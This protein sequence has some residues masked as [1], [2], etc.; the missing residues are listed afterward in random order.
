MCNSSPQSSTTPTER[1][2]FMYSKYTNIQSQKNKKKE[3][4]VRERERER[5]P[6][7]GSGGVFEMKG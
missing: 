3:N 7:M 6:D 2:I 1:G 4:C 5:F